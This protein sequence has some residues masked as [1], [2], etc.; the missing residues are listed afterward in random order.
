MWVNNISA[1]LPEAHNAFSS[2]DSVFALEGE[3]I[4]QSRLCTVSRVKLDG[5]TYYIKK[6]HKSAEGL[7]L[8]AP[9][10][11]GRREWRNLL[12][13]K[14][15]GLPA[16]ELAAYGE[17][18][19]WQFPRK[20]IVITRGIEQAP[21]LAHLYN[22][23]AAELRDDRWVRA[24][25]GQVAHATRVMHQHKFAH[26]DW[27]WRNI[28]ARNTE[29]GP[30][31]FMIDCPAGQHWTWPFFEYRRIKDLACLDKVANKVLSRT[32]RLRFYL[33]Y[34]ERN[35]LTADDKT[36]IRKITAFFQGRE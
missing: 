4:T 33:D 6:Y 9:L 22:T 18:S 35:R 13:F 28:L 23:A 11:K 21:D 27:K 7:S 1:E 2:L 20:A 29:A 34:C 24:V 17:Q 12:A 3:V 14:Q 31:I 32:Q 16:A 36:V 25:S 10:S 30:E 5:H 26:N 8:L 19:R 15:W